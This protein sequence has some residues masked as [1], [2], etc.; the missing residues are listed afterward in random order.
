[1]AT[2]RPRLPVT[3]KAKSPPASAVGE[4]SRSSVQVTV[5]T[6]RPPGSSRTREV[7]SFTRMVTERAPLPKADGLMAK[8][9]PVAPA[10]STPFVSHWTER[11]CEN[12]SCTATLKVAGDGPGQDRTRFVGVQASIGL[13]RSYT[14]STRASLQ[15]SQKGAK[16]LRIA[17]SSRGRNQP[18][19]L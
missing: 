4:M 16:E 14:E 10:T 7:L 18:V 1:M 15:T 19:G 3:R 12:G 5:C 13:T 11:A 8:L 6:N 2:G 17:Q 9:V